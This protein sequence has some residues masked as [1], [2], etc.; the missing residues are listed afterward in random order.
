MTAAAIGSLF[1]S[2]GLDTA[3]F[4]EGMKQAQGGLGQFA[5][6]MRTAGA[7]LSAG[8]T[9]PLAGLALGAQAAARSL[10][11]LDNQAR[12]AG[13]AAQ[14]FKVLAMA[15]EQFGVGQEKV[16]DI[17]KDVGDKVGDFLQNGAGPM[18]DF[19]DNIGPKVG[20][21]AEQFK[22]LNGRDAL[23]LY[24]SSL[25]KANLSQAEMTFYMEAIASD[26]SALL[27]VFSDNAKALTA[28]DV[29]AKR[30]GLNLNGDL[31]S[32]AKATETQF[33]ITKD[34]LGIQFQQ[35]LVQLA[36]AVSQ[37]M[38]AVIPLVT[39]LAGWVTDLA[40]AFSAL[41]P[42][43]QAFIAGAIGIAAAAGPVLVGIGAMIP[44]LS[45]LA[46]GFVALLSPIGLVV[47]AIAAVAAG[48]YLIYQNW[49][50]IAAYFQGLWDSVTA[51][52]TAA[53]DL[54]VSTVQG[55]KTAALTAID[56]LIQAV[57]A[58][59]IQMAADMRDWAGNVIDGF[60]QGF[61]DRIASAKESVTGFAGDVAGWFKD[62]LGIRSPSRVF[63]GFG[64]NISDGLAIGVKRSAD[65]AVDA[66]SSLA[67]RMA[68]AGKSAVEG[69]VDSFAGGLAKGDLGGAIRGAFSGYTNAA[70]NAAKDMFKTAFSGGGLKSITS[71]IGGAFNGIGAA[72]SGGAGFFGGIGKALSA[73]L[74][75]VGIATTIMGLIKSFGGT[76]QTGGGLDIGVSGG[77]VSGSS[78]KDM[79]STAFWGL[80]NNQWTEKSALDGELA[81]ALE[82]QV[83]GIQDGVKSIYARAGV[84]V[85]NDMINGFNF[86]F[87]RISTAG[88]SQEQITAEITDAF[89]RY[90]DGLSKAISGIGLQAVSIFADVSAVLSSAGQ[91]LRGG[92]KDIVAAAGEL[93]GMFGGADGLGKAVNNFVEKFFTDGQKVDI[94]Q[95]SV[96]AAFA[97]LG[98]AVPATMDGFRDLVLAQDLMTAAG[99]ANYAALLNVADAF[100]YVKGAG[101]QA[102]DAAKDAIAARFDLAFKSLDGRYVTQFDARLAQAGMA[103]G[104][105]VS[106]RIGVGGSVQQV[107]IAKN[108]TGNQLLKKIYDVLFDSTYQGARI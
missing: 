51:T 102:A 70:T 48:A 43:T 17:M 104:Y 50:G 53:V 67:D 33:R 10:G 31:I 12:V 26:A 71:T 87:G 86:A 77:Q 100:A 39:K 61:N 59:M 103:N 52:F 63:M 47:A 9:A 49:D 27:P 23:A 92:F 98:M 60:V 28:M 68:N 13:L 8:I 2:L 66:V 94:V 41:S 25:E 79:K 85:S 88:K 57:K 91:S 81:S 95:K 40:S 37:I 74:P 18:K 93:A 22:N 16:A 20:V 72:F 75:L 56:E 29:E 78:Y 21:T 30:L 4:T 3:A 65:V 99:R 90:Q 101:K 19:F 69:M 1:V 62:T 76:S 84:A 58:K 83:R 42:Q 73:A 97:S 36:P 46:A 11:E 7:A 38:T 6:K 5:A 108:D 105:D 82:K 45:T 106:A 54:V 55:M 96:T 14:D 34:V 64:E 15:S 89:S 80:V 107:V 24:V 32:A 44:L 35:A